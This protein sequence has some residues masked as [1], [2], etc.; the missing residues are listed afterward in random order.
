MPDNINNVMITNATRN[1][2]TV[3]N[4]I[5]FVVKVLV[6]PVVLVASFIIC[7]DHICYICELD[8]WIC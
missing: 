8:A 6:S 4:I 3:S 2:I 1:N 5:F 7:E